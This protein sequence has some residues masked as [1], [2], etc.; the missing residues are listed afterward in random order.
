MNEFEDA[1][2][3]EDESSGDDKNFIAFATSV[4]SHGSVSKFDGENSQKCSSFADSGRFI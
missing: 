2:D 1:R 3:E 4:H